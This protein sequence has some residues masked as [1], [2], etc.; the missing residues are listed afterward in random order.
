[1]KRGSRPTL[2][3]SLFRYL[4]AI[5]ILAI[6]VWYGRSRS[7]PDLVPFLHEIFPDASEFEQSE[8]VYAALSDD[9]ELLGWAATGSGSGYGGPMLV[10]VGLDTS[11]SVVGSRVVEHR[12]TPLFF[13]MVRAPAFFKEAEGRNFAEI[14]Y[15]YSEIVGVTGATMSSEAI[16]A[17]VRNAVAGIAGPEFNIRLPRPDRPFEFGIFELVILLLFVIAI[18]ATRFRGRRADLIRWSSQAAG[19]LVIGFWKNSPI[20]IAKIT[21]LISG[22]FPDIRTNLSFYLLIGGFLFTVLVVGRGIYCTHIC[23]FGAAQ[24]FINM[25]GG[26]RIKLPPWS[27]TLMTRMRSVIVFS[28]I[29]AAL[30]TAQPALT[31]YEP[32]AVLFALKG[33]VLQWFLLLIVMISSLFIQRPWCNF[34]CPVRSC[35]RVVRDLRKRVTGLVEVQGIE[36]D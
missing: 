25:I 14:N 20:T 17:G 9:A 31:S 6:A 10:V 12:E 34:F 18:I 21:V 3:S 36:C 1:M 5:A 7:G 24:Q 4:P 19:L 2:K 11:G 8:G 15:S 13:R 16:V 30:A 33:T 28:V 35:E 26:K 29:I 27:I 32:F 22:Y 23:P